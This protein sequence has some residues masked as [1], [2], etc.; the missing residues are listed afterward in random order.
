ME[1]LIVGII[2]LFLYATADSVE[3]K[4]RILNHSILMLFIL[5]GIIVVTE[6]IPWEKLI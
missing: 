6:Y 3:A 5:I 2:T 1:V 4:K